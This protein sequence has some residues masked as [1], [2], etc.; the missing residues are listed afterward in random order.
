MDFTVGGHIE[1]AV[2]VAGVAEGYIIEYAGHGNDASL[3]PPWISSSPL[4]AQ[5]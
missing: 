4:Q 3:L 5:W 2:E 1:M